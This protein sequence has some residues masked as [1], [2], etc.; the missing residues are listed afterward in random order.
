MDGQQFVDAVRV[1][2]RDS[3]V[4]G[5]LALLQQPPG[6]RPSAALR[7]NAAWYASLSE[8]DRD[9]LA[10]IMQEVVDQAVFG[11]LCV[12]DGVRAIED[13]PTKGTFELTYVGEKTTLL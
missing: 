5:T 10:S 4:S 6:R 11:L 9:R 13:G 2:V 7:N 8:S 3:A 12:I 1:A